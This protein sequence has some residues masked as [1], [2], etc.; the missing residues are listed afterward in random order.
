MLGESLWTLVSRGVEVKLIAT[1]DGAGYEPLREALDDRRSDLEASGRFT[2][3]V[4]ADTNHI[5]SP[6]WAQEWLRDFLLATLQD[7]QSIGVAVPASPGVVSMR[8]SAR[9]AVVEDEPSR[10]K[11]GR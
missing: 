7:M 6:L 8:D 10:T 11:E 3:D 2:L 9:S 5:F 1:S 4:L